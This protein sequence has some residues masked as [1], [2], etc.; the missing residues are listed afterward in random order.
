EGALPLTAEIAQAMVVGDQ[1]PYLVAIIVP[2]PEFAQHHAGRGADLAAL[3]NDAGFLK[4]L[5]DV[6]AQVNATLPAVERVRRFVIASEAFTTAHGQMTPT[7]K[8]R[9]HAIRAAYGE[10]LDAL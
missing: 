5:G 1:R 3:A 10:A 6:V 9:R 2:D 7:L 8:I 4:E